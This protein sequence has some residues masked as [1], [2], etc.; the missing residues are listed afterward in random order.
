MHAVMRREKENRALRVAH[1]FPFQV[2]RIYHSH[3][4]KCN[5]SL[6]RLAHGRFVWSRDGPSGIAHKSSLC[7]AACGCVPAIPQLTAA[8]SIATAGSLRGACA[9]CSDSPSHAISQQCRGWMLVPS[10]HQRNLRRRSRSSSGHGTSAQTA[11]RCRR[12]TSCSV[13][14]AW[15]RSCRQVCG[16]VEP[17]LLAIMSCAWVSCWQH[18]VLLYQ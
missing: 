14:A 5:G 18:L 4:H 8:L 11:W 3:P 15:N 17:W 12:E 9:L 2:S 6:P 10:W 1:C 13:R 16:D 7:V